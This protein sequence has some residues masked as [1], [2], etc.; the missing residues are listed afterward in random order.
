MVLKLLHFL[1]NC[2]TWLAKYIICKSERGIYGS[3]CT[4]TVS[5]I[6]VKHLCAPNW[7]WRFMWSNNGIKYKRLKMHFIIPHVVHFG[8]RKNFEYTHVCNYFRLH[9]GLLLGHCLLCLQLTV[10]PIPVIR[11]LFHC[12]D[13]ARNSLLKVGRG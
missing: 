3:L 10:L 5:E 8:E 7:P 6:R 9:N 11:Y 4:I 12:L 2:P 13:S 1:A